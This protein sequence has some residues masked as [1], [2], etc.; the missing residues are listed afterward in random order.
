M[1]PWLTE[2]GFRF[3]PVDTALREP[4][5]LLAAG[6]NL[7]PPTLLAAYQSGIFPWYGDGDP[8]LWWSPDPRCVLAP[9]EIHISRSMQKFL[10]ND[11]FTYRSNTVFAEVIRQCSEPRNH[12]SSTWLTEEMIA[13]YCTL[14]KEGHAHSIEV[15]HGEN[16]AGGLYGIAIGSVFFGESMF[17]R[18]TN[19]SKAGFIRLARVLSESGYGLIDCQVASPHMISLGAKMMKREDFVQ[20]IR[21]LTEQ[22]PSRP[23]PERFLS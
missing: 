10:K 17:S 14:H 4:N 9:E 7:L 13:A 3:P 19:A 5:G 6:G 12:T 15:W 23:F 21:Q 20:K 22:K 16:L 18:V 2:T 1:I 11:P 8:I